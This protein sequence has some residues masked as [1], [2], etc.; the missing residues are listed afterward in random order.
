MS[1]LVVNPPDFARILAA[2]KTQSSLVYLD[3]YT[4]SAGEDRC[5]GVTKC[6]GALLFDQRE[7]A[8]SW[9]FGG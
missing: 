8:S 4:T 6:L 5:D 2:S 1:A 9:T 3:N 7:N